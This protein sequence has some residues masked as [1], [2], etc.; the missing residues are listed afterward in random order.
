MLMNSTVSRPPCF[1]C[2]A[3]NI[4]DETT[5]EVLLEGFGVIPSDS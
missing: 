2:L 3:L 5:K 4:G 1:S